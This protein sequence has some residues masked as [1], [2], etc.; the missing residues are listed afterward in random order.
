MNH[1]FKALGA[2]LVLLVIMLGSAKGAEKNNPLWLLV[3]QSPIISKGALRV[4]I[5]AI[6]ELRASGK[7]DYVNL[8]IE[9]AEFLKGSAPKTFTIRW[10]SEGRDYAPDLPLLKQLNGREVVVFTLCA[11][12]TESRAIY[13]AGHTPE[14]LA[15]SSEVLIRNIQTEIERQKQLLAQFP[16]GIEEIP[17]SRIE[18][19]RRLIE[20]MTLKGR[21]EAAFEEMLRLGQ[22]IVP[23][24]IMLMD[25]R[26]AVTAEWLQ[27]PNAPGHW[28]AYALYKPEKVVDA[29][30][31]ILGKITGQQFVNIVNGGTDED[32]RDAVDGWRVYLYSR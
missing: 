1:L 2:S 26:R 21:A 19:V 22:D 27:I 8:E 11:G 32:R 23:A 16:K 17:K 31:G 5:S 4:P 12:P 3:A 9:N 28:E 10:F 15:A 7:R 29:L 18:S 6:E 14:A 25:D 24:T 30:D 13:L 20:N